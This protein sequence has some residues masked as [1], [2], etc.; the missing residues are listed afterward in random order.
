MPSLSDAYNY[1]I[2][3]CNWPYVGY[4]QPQRETIDITVNYRTYCDCS[5]LMS[6]GLTVGGYYVNNP[7]FVTA[8]EQSYLSRIG[9]IQED[10][11]GI[12]QP[13]DILWRSGHT[14]MVYT[15]GN[16]GGVTMGA[17]TSK[18]AFEN[19]VSINDYTS[20]AS[21]WSQLWRDPTQSATSHKWHQSNGYLDEYGDYMTDNAYMVYSYFIKLGFTYEAIAGLLGNMQQESTINP[22]V[23]QNQSAQSGGYGLVQW[24]PASG[25]FNYAAT[26][27]INT[28]DPDSNGDGQCQCINDCESEG[29]WIPTS[30]YPYTW[31]QFSQLTDV[32]EAVRAFLYEYERAG[33]AALDNRLRYAAHWYDIIKTG[34]WGAGDPG[35]PSGR[36]DVIRRGA[37]SELMRRLVIPGRH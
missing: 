26:H 25:Y 24:T 30:A 1:V 29:Q 28:S 23:W 35:T 19:Q 34:A 5:S 22:G 10:I 33:I 32:N 6:K 21:S 18:Y 2:A 20:T 16:G 36:P 9:W 31:A 11:N 37:V 3:A 8:N 14:E 27:G 12:W 17:H 13:G 7:W 4:S 15:G